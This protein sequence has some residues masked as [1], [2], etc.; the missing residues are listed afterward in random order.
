MK[1]PNSCNIDPDGDLV[2]ILLD[3]GDTCERVV[4]HLKGNITLSLSQSGSRAKRSLNGQVKVTPSESSHAVARKSSDAEDGQPQ[5]I[6]LNVSSKHL[7]L[8]SP[9]FKTLLRGGFAESKDLNKGLAAEVRLPEDHPAALWLLLYIIHGQP[10]RAPDWVDL[11]M[12]TE[13]AVLVDKYELHEATE[14]I[15]DTWCTIIENAKY[16][17]TCSPNQHLQLICVSW[18]FRKPKMFF[19]RTHLAMRY[20]DRDLAAEGV[21]DLPIPIEVLEKVDHARTRALGLCLGKVQGFYTQYLKKPSDSSIC[22]A[23]CDTMVL[24]A[25]M[26]GLAAENLVPFPV[27]PYKGISYSKL[28]EALSGMVLSSLCEAL[29][30]M[31]LVSNLTKKQC[32]IK[33]A[34]NRTVREAG[35]ALKGL[36][37][38]E[39]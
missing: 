1:L 32:S 10:K 2:L 19:K 22:S 3:H 14:I 9:V 37:L 11:G 15:T 20:S 28:S 5:E 12:L 6:R 31:N 36:K 13:V 25:L 23:Y 17:A 8:A 38:D 7:T 16:K 33:N 35:L 21:T 18:V 26:K 34:L 4:K 39:F 24:G 30:G 27:S 29:V